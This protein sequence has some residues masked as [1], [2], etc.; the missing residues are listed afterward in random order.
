VRFKDGEV[1][2]RNFETHKLWRFSWL[3][4]IETS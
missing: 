2:D 3:P 1:L 4:K